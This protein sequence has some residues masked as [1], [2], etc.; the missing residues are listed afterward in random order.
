MNAA[1]SHDGDVLTDLLY[2]SRARGAAFSHS[3]ARG[4]W[5]LSFGAVAGLAVHVIV[6]GEVQLW[7]DAS[8]EAI[9]LLP[10]DV[11]LLRG[12][13]THHLA[14]LAGARCVPLERLLAAGPM[15]GSARR[16]LV[17]SHSDGAPD[18]VFCCGAYMFD[19][20]LCDGLIE[21]LPEVVRVRPAAGSTLRATADLFAREMLG[22]QPGQQ[23]LLDRLLDVALI[24]VLREH[25][26][27]HGEQAPPWFAASSD[28]QIG[29]ALRALHADP[30]HAWTVA[31]LADRAA[32]SRAAFARR[33]T[34]LLGVAPLAYLTDWR[35]ALARERLRDGDE[36]LAAIAASV[37]YASEFSFAA[38]F[39]RHSGVAPGRWRA[40]VRQCAPD[41]A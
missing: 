38:A 11:V 4:D 15:P 26:A 27:A 18:A 24:H 20:D 1:A 39:K 9:G 29:G 6:D 17:G 33:F 13:V 23:T 35:M 28:P 8:A 2:R 16:F 37:G 34:A 19:G 14:N 3:T 41:A 25:F 22:E 30:A 21:A 32:L 5:G 36:P 40:A 31:E 12:S 10:G 7:T